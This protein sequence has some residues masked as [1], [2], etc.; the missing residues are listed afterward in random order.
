MSES[1]AAKFYKGVP[2][3]QYDSKEGFYT[4]PCNSKV[5]A[6][7]K[8]KSGQSFAINEADFNVGRASGSSNRCLG[9]VMPARTNG[10]AVLGMT[11]LKNAYSVLDY[12]QKRVGLAEYAF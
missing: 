9:A 6:V 11:F 4:Y 2:S 12:Q 7:V 1:D 10:M 8:T 3:S 5:G